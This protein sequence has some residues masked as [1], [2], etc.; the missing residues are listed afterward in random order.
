[1]PTVYIFGR[2]TSYNF[3]TYDEPPFCIYFATTKE[4][5][6]SIVMEHIMEKNAGYLT[7]PKSKIIIYNNN[8][9]ISIHDTNDYDFNQHKNYTLDDEDRQFLFEL[10]LSGE[11]P[12]FIDI[13][14]CYFPLKTIDN[15]DRFDPDQI[16]IIDKR[17]IEFF[18][19][20]GRFYNLYDDRY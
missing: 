12:K 2:F 13:A 7:I 18:K 4:W 15:F 14:F 11:L 3:G 5:L 16:A 20:E 1:M 10:K 9:D 6:F 19:K 17:N 8:Y